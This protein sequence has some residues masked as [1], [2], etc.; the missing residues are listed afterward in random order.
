[1]TSARHLRI[2]PH[3]VRADDNSEGAFVEFHGYHRTKIIVIRPRELKIS[4][5]RPELR[6]ATRV[7]SVLHLR[8]D[9]GSIPGASTLFAY[10]ARTVS[11]PR[12]FILQRTLY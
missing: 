3:G 8:L 10:A 4:Q 7:D 5:S 9:P 1:M 6:G 11:G 12:F 2:A